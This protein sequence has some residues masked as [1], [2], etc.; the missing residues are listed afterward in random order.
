M[1]LSSLKPRHPRFHLEFAPRQ[2]G[3]EGVSFDSA[4]PGRLV[5]VPR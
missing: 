3:R 2:D 5:V 4:A 1:V